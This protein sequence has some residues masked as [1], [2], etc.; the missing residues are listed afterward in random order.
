MLEEGI[1]FNDEEILFLDENNKV[2]RGN[3]DFLKSLIYEQPADLVTICELE[4]Q[5]FQQNPTWS[6]GPFKIFSL[7]P[8]VN[9]GIGTHNPQKLL[10]VNGV[11]QTKSLIVGRESSDFATISG[12]RSGTSNQ[13]VLSLGIYNPQNQTEHVALELKS[14]GELSINHNSS[15]QGATGRVLTISNENRKIVYVNASEETLYAR[16]IVVDEY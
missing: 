7:C 9:I 13:P 2:I 1:S 14:A 11:A 3:K 5:P 4:G 16:K 15:Y 8:A 10:D 6:N 12:F